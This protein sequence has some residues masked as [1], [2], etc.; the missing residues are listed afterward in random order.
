MKY[1]GML[2]LAL[3]CAPA[4]AAEEEMDPAAQKVTD[5]MR[6]N[7]PAQLTVGQLELTVFD[8]TGGSRT[9]KGRMYS[10]KIDKGLLHASLR[11]DAP[12][13][14]KGAAY[15]VQET[16]DYLRDGMFVYL[17][18]VRRVRRVTGTFADASL[19]GTNFSYFE[20]KQLENAFGD[21]RAKMQPDEKVN[22]RPVSVLRFEALPGAETKYTRVQAWVDQQA[23]VVV[24]AEFY[25]NKKLSKQLSSPA[26]SLKQAGPNWYVSEYEMRDPS[27]GTRTVLRVAKLDSEKVPP[28]QY[29]DPNLFFMAP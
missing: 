28:N 17:P 22:D 1:I 8:R 6:A 16:E 4:L 27:A 14:L 15:L 12:T 21:L 23:C 20:F 24:R 9:L 11:V 13:E 2:A 29:F 5:C 10:R 26:G 3:L 25:E 19:M 7:V 18:S